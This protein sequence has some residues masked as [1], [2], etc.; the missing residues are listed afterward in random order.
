MPAH[1]RED[2]RLRAKYHDWCSAKIVEQFL[3][4]S[5]EEVYQLAQP[6]DPGP[7]DA[8]AADAPE[9]EPSVS[10]AAKPVASPTAQEASFQQLV[11]RVT[12]MLLQR[13]ELPSFEEWSAAYGEEPERFEAEMLG[14]WKSPE[15]DGEG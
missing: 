12:E 14:F 11:R 5:P 9:A 1:P 7:A 6:G 3:A 15:S 2:A 13:T 4:L 8:T 10:A